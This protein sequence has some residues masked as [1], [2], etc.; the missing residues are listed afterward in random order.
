MSFNTG[1][2]NRLPFNRSPVQPVA[3]EVEFNVGLDLDIIEIIVDDTASVEF[4]SGTEISLEP[5]LIINLETDFNAG[6]DL[7]D[8][9]TKVLRAEIDLNAGLDLADEI[10][11]VINLN[12]EF[13]ASL[14]IIGDF[15]SGEIEELFIDLTMQPGDILVI[16]SCNYTVTL[17]GGN[18]YELRS[19]DWV[20]LRE[21]SIEL[22]VG[23]DDPGSLEVKVDAVPCYL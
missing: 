13:A 15:F 19:G 7:P 21:K 5:L 4:D 20:F 10:T 6:T 9:I 11:K 22:V 23:S 1:G 18:I 8:A 16:N 12:T 14:D 17:N 2:F 3:I